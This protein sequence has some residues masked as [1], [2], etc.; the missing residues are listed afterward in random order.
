M[1]NVLWMCLIASALFVR[2]LF[3]ERWQNFLIVRISERFPTILQSLGRPLLE[4]NQSL[5]GSVY[6]HFALFASVFLRSDLSFAMKWAENKISA[7][8][9]VS[10]SIV[11]KISSHSI[12]HF[13]ISEFGVKLFGR[14]K[15]I[16]MYPSA[17]FAINF[18]FLNQSV[19]LR[20]DL[21]FAKKW[22]E[23][24]IIWRKHF[25]PQMKFNL[26]AL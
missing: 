9:N 17:L 24:E 7:H 19:F 26:F 22:A 5:F 23:N 18:G 8:K 12:Q 3:S 14:P 16:W 11:N 6:G 2:T 15:W 10:Y 1:Q 4:T 20:Y 13:H 25:A 21:S